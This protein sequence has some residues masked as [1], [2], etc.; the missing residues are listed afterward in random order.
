MAIPYI[1]KQK[2][3]SFN[4]KGSFYIPLS[5]NRYDNKVVIACYSKV[6]AM[7]CGKKRLVPRDKMFFG[8]GASSVRGYGYQMLG[9]VNDDKNPVGGESMFEVGVE[10]RVKVSDNIGVVVFI[11]AGNVYNSGLPKLNKKLLYGCGIGVRYYTLLA[12]IRLDIGF[13]F[14]RRKTS[15]G[16]KI[17]SLFNVYISIGQAF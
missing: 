17:D 5:K 3:T 6:G 9:E 12:P 15:T 1:C 2:L 13:P 11:E 16:K 14:T 8:G 10:P 4:A 7:L